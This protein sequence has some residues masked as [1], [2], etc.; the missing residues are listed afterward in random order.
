MDYARR[1][2]S[3]LIMCSHFIS[4]RLFRWLILYS[5]F[6]FSTSSPFPVLLTSVLS[7]TSCCISELIMQYKSAI[8][9]NSVY[10]CSVV[11]SHITIY[12]SRGGKTPHIPCTS[13]YS[14]SVVNN[15]AT[16]SEGRGGKTPHIP[17]TSVYSYSV[18]N[19]HATISG[20]RGGK[21][22]HIPC[23]SVYSYSVVNS[24]ATISEGRGGKTPHI[25]C[26]S[27]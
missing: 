11:N 10:S 15:H 25:P 13:V 21:T 19:S 24:H 27:V 7:T 12:E 16:V 9:R 17:C 14:Y 6:F 8:Y 23:T 26:T 4:L 3:S 2:G 5:V 1:A 22:P 18:V 20:G